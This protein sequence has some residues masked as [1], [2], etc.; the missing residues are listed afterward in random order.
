[1]LFGQFVP[2]L[3]GGY[4]STPFYMLTAYFKPK[5]YVLFARY[6]PA[7]KCNAP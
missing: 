2:R 5:G 7:Y 1:M 4:Q 6:D 3:F